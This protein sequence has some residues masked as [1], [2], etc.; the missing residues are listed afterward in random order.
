VKA[1]SEGSVQREPHTCPVCGTKFFATADRAFCPVCILHRAFGTE[2]AATGESGSA[3]ELAAST[4]QGDRGSQVRRFEN[5]EVMLAADGRPIE[6]GRGAMGVTY[7]ALDVDL[8]CPVT[9]KVIS[10]RYL[11]DES[12][13]HRFLREARAATS[14]RHPNVASV[15]HL[16]RTGENY[17]YA[18]EFVEGETLESLIKGEPHQT[19]RPTGG[20][21]G[22]RNREPGRCRFG[23][24]AQK[25][26]RTHRSWP[27]EGD[28]RTP[29]RSWHFNA[30]SFAGTP[31]FA[32]PEQFAGVPFDMLFSDFL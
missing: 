21:A 3:S 26:P 7:K 4:E 8:R 11:G 31:E 10:E 6:L 22:I 13:R 14:V 20:K 32:S 23:H 16:G 29:F 12:A 28:K 24:S 25:E 17:F 30:R 5:Y 18:M 9:L 2:S 19:L 27:G 1:E 15:F